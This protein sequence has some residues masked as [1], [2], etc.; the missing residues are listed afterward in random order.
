MT[1]A[2]MRAILGLDSSFSDEEVITRYGTYEAAAADQG[3]SISDVRTHLRIAADETDEDAYLGLLTMAARR[4]VENVI[5]R[6]FTLSTDEPDLAL[7]KTAMLLLIG[8]W[9]EHRETVALGSASSEMPL[10]V[11]F[12]LMPLKKWSC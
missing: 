10:T 5:D 2:D 7:I 8:H 1:V 4:A 12:L 6:P 3:L 9:Y 11:T